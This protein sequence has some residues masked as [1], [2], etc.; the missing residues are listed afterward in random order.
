MKKFFSA[1]FITESD[2]DLFDTLL[3]L[4][5][6]KYISNRS[7]IL[8]DIALHESLKNGKSACFGNVFVHTARS[9]GI[10]DFCLSCSETENGNIEVLILW[11]DISEHYLGRLAEIADFF[12]KASFQ[13]KS[14]EQIITELKKL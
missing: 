14:N 11:N 1:R 7:Q 13:H 8:K 3:D 4:I 9:F 12:E 6:S 2:D 10:T 5:D